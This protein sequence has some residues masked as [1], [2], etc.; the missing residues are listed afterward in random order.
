MKH[1]KRKAIPVLAALIAASAAQADN[2]SG[3]FYLQG[4]LG[5]SRIKAD[6]QVLEFKD[7]GILPRI[8][9]G[10]DF[11]NYRLA[12]DYTHYQKLEA[13]L[14]N[15]FAADVKTRG[16]GLSLIYDFP[17]E[18][19]FKPYLGSRFAF[20]NI[21]MNASRAGYRTSSDE[22]KFGTGFI[23]GAG[24]ELNGNL[25]LDAGYRFNRIAKD[26]DAHEIT[27]GLR[28]TF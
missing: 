17:L 3:G 2:T 19:R 8:S 18:G 26:F 1:T 23:A 25:T 10:Y 7:T 5:V 6:A 13:G 22:T 11:G 12:A 27:A 28:Y 15:G 4:D 21:K 9:A 16:A 20:N 14:P 24:Y